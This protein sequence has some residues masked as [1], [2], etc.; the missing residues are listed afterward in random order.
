MKETSQQAEPFPVPGACYK[1]SCLAYPPFWMAFGII[2]KSSWGALRR[3]PG[4]LGGGRVGGGGGRGVVEWGGRGTHQA[5]LP[6]VASWLST[7]FS[8]AGRP[9]HHQKIFQAWLLE[10]ERRIRKISELGTC[11]FSITQIELE[12]DNFCIEKQTSKRKQPWRK[13][14]QSTL[15]L[16]NSRMCMYACSIFQRSL[17]PYASSTHILKITSAYFF[18]CRI[19]NAIRNIHDGVLNENSSPSN[20]CMCM[21]ID[22]FCNGTVRN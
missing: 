8:F 10:T 4:H 17:W 2:A 1:S 21:C 15:Y 5:H 3:T 18:W 9:K 11:A 19:F 14:T 7:Y 12:A 22:S 6:K 20:M 13:L 16:P